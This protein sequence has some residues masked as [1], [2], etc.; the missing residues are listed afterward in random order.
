MLRGVLP[1]NLFGR[2][3]RAT[4][5]VSRFFSLLDHR[6]RVIAQGLGCLH[7]LSSTHVALLGVLS[8]PL[9]CLPQ[10]AFCGCMSAARRDHCFVNTNAQ[11]FNSKVREKQGSSAV[12][13]PHPRRCR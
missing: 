6:M 5:V 13:K 12:L 10:G 1:A 7:A 2:M 9:R 4:S 3:P 8:F 11:C